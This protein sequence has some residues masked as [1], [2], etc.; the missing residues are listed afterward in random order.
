MR[1]SYKASLIGLVLVGVCLTAVGLGGCGG[2]EEPMIGTRR[3][4]LEIAVPVAE[5]KAPLAHF[6]K[7]RTGLV[8]RE[9]RTGTLSELLDLLDKEKVDVLIVP[10]PVYAVASEPY[11]LLAIM[12]AK[13]A[14]TVETRGMILVRADRGLVTVKDAADLTVAAVGPTSVPGCLLQRALVTEQDAAPSTVTYLGDEAAV[15]RAVYNGEADLGFVEWRLD[16]ARRPAD[17]RALVARDVPDVFEAVV[18]LAVT[19]A[20]PHDAV[21]VRARV[22]DAVRTELVKALEEFATDPSGRAYLVEHYGVEGLVPSDDAEYADFRTEL[23]AAGITLADLLP[24]EEE[25]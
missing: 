8:C 2:G 17:A 22:P 1:F 9:V 5:R 3:R 23:K 12:K 18:P 7:E 6:I 10:A 13:R 24:E 21:A 14:G 15:V 4:P 20:V 16:K 25:E 19:N 11:G